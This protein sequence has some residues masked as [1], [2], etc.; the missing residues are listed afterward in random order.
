[1]TI[2]TIAESETD[3]IEGIK[4][5]LDT[6][7][8]FDELKKFYRLARH[9]KYDAFEKFKKK[10]NMNPTITVE[11]AAAVY[12][13]A[14]KQFFPNGSFLHKAQDYVSPILPYIGVK[15]KK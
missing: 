14:R 9:K 11:E 6:K 13:F 12:E 1:M 4:E 2:D 10:H 5:R 3:R 15:P 8:S 7:L